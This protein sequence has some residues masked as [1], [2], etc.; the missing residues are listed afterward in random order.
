MICK[1]ETLFLQKKVDTCKIYSP[2]T[3][4]NDQILSDR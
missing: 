1:I 3:R 4:K 2:N